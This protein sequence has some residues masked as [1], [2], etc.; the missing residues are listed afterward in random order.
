M[1]NF[2]ASV[3]AVVLGGVS[4]I[5]L[6]S[7]SIPV[8]QLSDTDGIFIQVPLTHEFYRYSEYG[9]LRDVVVLDAEKNQLPYRVLPVT[10]PVAKPEQTVTTTALSF[11]PVAVDATPDTLRQLHA[12]Q[13]TVLTNT[14]QENTVQIATSTQPLSIKTPEFYL[15]DI[16]QLD[17]GVSSLLIDWDAQANNQYLQ[18]ELEATSDLQRWVPLSS[19]TLV[20]ISQQDHSVKRNRIDASI[21]K[22]TYEFLRLRIIR[23]ADNLH[24][25]G[26]TAEQK[27][28]TQKVAAEPN[29][30]WLLTGTLAK[31]QT[32]VY[33]PNEHTKT[34]SVSAWE[35]T[36]NEA[37]PVGT[38][39]IDL[40]SDTYGDTA[41][42]FSRAAENKNWQLLYQ[43]VWFNA[44]VGAQWQR[45]DE[46]IV[47]PNRD[48]YW[49][50]ELNESAKNSINPRLRF[51]WH[52]SMLQII[53]NDKP[54]FT[55]AINADAND[56]NNRTRIFNQLIATA[57]PVWANATLLPLNA[58]PESLASAS[59][60]IDWKQVVFWAALVLAVAVLLVFSLRL[61]KQL[62]VDGSKSE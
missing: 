37:T 48:K 46:L 58:T 59:S 19:A 26:I 7:T 13:V 6:A 45:S 38:V 49:R 4:V 20:Q 12:T 21:P 1:N 54:P 44:Q 36:R 17:H 51:G 47:L 41:R 23:G 42:I 60:S 55:L 16:R 27:I 2:F 53:A 9:D 43:G 29:D 8:F 15:L 25:T 62:N 56:S 30:T 33:F 28:T 35:F 57:Q 31:T 61:F 34:Y 24:L 10:T 18:V 39:A 32:G 52:P 14:L 22:K 11:S 50:I 3:V 5:S 40:G